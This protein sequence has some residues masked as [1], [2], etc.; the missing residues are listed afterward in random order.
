MTF[1]PMLQ[2]LYSDLTGIHAQ[3]LRAVITANW[4]PLVAT[5]GLG[6]CAVEGIEYLDADA[7]QTRH[8]V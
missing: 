3:V 1:A 5:W 7:A 8:P 4:L 6:L 2:H